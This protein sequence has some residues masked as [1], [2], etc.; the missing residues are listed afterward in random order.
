M[1]YVRAHPTLQE[2][3]SSAFG[4]EV[5]VKPPLTAVGNYTVLLRQ[6]ADQATAVDQVI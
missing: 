6:V 4:V 3:A 2:T 1:N 5:W